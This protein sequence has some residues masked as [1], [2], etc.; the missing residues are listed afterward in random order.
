MHFH[1]YN[2]GPEDVK[3]S[4]LDRPVVR[5]ISHAIGYLLL[6]LFVFISISRREWPE[7]G[8]ILFAVIIIVYLVTDIRIMKARKMKSRASVNEMTDPH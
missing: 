6:L 2:S 8:I 1:K 3:Q 4:F 7:S 5:R